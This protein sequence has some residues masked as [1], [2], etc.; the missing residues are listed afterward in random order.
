[1]VKEVHS[2]SEGITNGRS[3]LHIIRNYGVV[4]CT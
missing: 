1:M 2:G 3:I 4:T